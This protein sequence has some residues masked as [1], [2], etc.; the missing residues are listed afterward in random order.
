[1]FLPLFTMFPLKFGLQ[2]FEKVGQLKP[3]AAPT[4]W[5]GRGTLAVVFSRLGKFL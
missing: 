4:C 5:P 2:L 1:V 3:P